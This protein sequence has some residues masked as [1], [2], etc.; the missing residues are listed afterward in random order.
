MAKQDNSHM[1]DMIEFTTGEEPGEVDALVKVERDFEI[2]VSAM[3]EG[4]ALVN[5]DMAM[6]RYAPVPRLPFLMGIQ[7]EMKDPDADGFYTE[8]EEPT[9]VAIQNRAVDVLEKEGH[10]KFVGAVTYN[11]MRMLYFY[12]KDDNYLPPLVGKIAAEYSHYEFNFMSEKDG[13]WQFYMNALYPPDVDLAHIRNRHVLQDLVDRGFDLEETYPVS[14]F[15]LFQDGASRVQAASEFRLLGYEIIDD[16]IYEEE[17]EPMAYGLRIMQRH[18]LDYMTVT[19][20]TYECYEV[21]EEFIGIVDGW[22]ISPAE[23]IEGWL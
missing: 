7:I 16:H 17:L 2:Y 11:G 3:D 15:F 1:T 10:A 20:K 6:F 5:V 8:E 23:D 13:S 21:M 22:E 18:P 4:R 9:L 14:Y 19:E 12:G